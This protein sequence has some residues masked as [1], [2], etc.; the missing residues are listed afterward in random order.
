[1]SYETVSHID[2]V[3]MKD[4]NRYLDA[5]YTLLSVSNYAKAAQRPDGTL[6]TRKGV[7]YVVAW[8][9]EDAPWVNVPSLGSA[10][11]S[12]TSNLKPH[13]RNGSSPIASSAEKLP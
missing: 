11:S 5:G 12:P 3:G 10:E 1:M 2:E 7:S 6:Y 13:P 4:I 9:K 8:D